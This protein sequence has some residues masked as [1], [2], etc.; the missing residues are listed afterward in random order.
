MFA[1]LFKMFPFGTPRRFVPV[2]QKPDTRL[3]KTL[4]HL[5]DMKGGI[6]VNGVDVRRVA[7]MAYAET[8]EYARAG[9]ELIARA[10]EPGDIN[11][12]GVDLGKLA[13]DGLK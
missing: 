12:D 13:R 3:Y 2:T 8:P 10:I 9:L 1:F 7:T 5:R 6:H 11:I 4:K